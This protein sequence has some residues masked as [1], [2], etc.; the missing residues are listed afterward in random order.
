MRVTV[1][2]T[3]AYGQ[4]VETSDP[5]G[6]I[7]FDPPVNTDAPTI[8]GS[9]LQRTSTLTATPG[10]WSGSGNSVRYQWQ[11][12]DGSDWVA[13]PNATTSSYRLAKE[14]EGLHVR[15]LVSMSNPDGSAD[16]PSAASAAQVAP[17]PPAN[18]SPRRS[19]ASRSAARS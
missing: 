6:P 9:S 15:V 12:E 4:A 1:T 13:I 16:R 5:V 14:D 8:S 10:T 19:P 3:N 2:A 17:F 7:A 11:R 18:R